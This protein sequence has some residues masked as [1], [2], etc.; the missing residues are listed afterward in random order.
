MIQC[1]TIPLLFFAFCI[2]GLDSFGQTIL[3]AGP[4]TTFCKGLFNTDTLTLGTSVKIQGAQ[5]PV[6]YAWECE[7]ILSPTLAFTASDFLDDTTKLTPYF[8]DYLTWPDWISFVLNV[9]DSIGNQATDSL[10]VRFS[11]FGYANGTIQL[12]INH[13]DSVL[14][15]DALIGGGIKPLSFKWI[16][17]KWLT[18]PDT[19][20]TWCK[21]DSSISYS[22]IATD[23]IGCIS[24]RHHAYIITVEP[25]G[26]FLSEQIPSKILQSGTMIKFI[27]IKDE[28]IMLSIYSLNGILL[29]EKNI[30]NDQVDLADLTD[31]TGLLIAYITIGD[32]EYNIKYLKQR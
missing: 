2:V 22:Q 30:L 3:D 18:D 32:S 13:G 17:E 31:N 23:S 14:L 12:S 19:L 5:G 6:I 20:I 10:K 29:A 25:V 15:S 28:P 9:E 8:I 27:N 1:K 21:P 4:D 24:E 11:S 7:Y 16:P 26:I